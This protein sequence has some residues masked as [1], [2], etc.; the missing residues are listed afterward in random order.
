MDETPDTTAELGRAHKTAADHYRTADM[1]RNCALAN[2][3]SVNRPVTDDVPDPV[4]P[5]QAAEKFDQH[6]RLA[7]VHARLAQV[8]IGAVQLLQQ[9][10]QGDEDK[11]TRRQRVAV[12]YEL[13]AWAE[14]IA[15]W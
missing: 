9:H 15:P 12:E 1:H 5:W 13:T 6:M 4:D 8:R 7:E 10:L 14:T 11:G 2:L 3:R